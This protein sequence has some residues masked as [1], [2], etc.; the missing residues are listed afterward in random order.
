MYLG[1][2]ESREFASKRE[3]IISYSYP[4]PP[5]FLGQGH[6]LQTPACHAFKL[7]CLFCA[8]WT[9]LC[10]LEGEHQTCWPRKSFC[11]FFLFFFFFLKE[12]PQTCLYFQRQS[13]ERRWRGREGTIAS[14]VLASSAGKLYWLLSGLWKVH[15]NW[16][17]KRKTTNQNH[18][19]A[20]ALPPEFG[21]PTPQLGGDSGQCLG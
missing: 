8:R 7:V 9:F 4:T 15:W 11:F 5:L 14:S 6:T 2:G 18:K 10:P 19:Q 1:G 12:F 20:C 21:D 16:A 17:G 3:E 13:W